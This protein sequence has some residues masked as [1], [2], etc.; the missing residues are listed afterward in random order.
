MGQAIHTRCTFCHQPTGS[1]EVKDG[2]DTYCN[3][4]CQEFS[5]A[6]HLFTCQV[7]ETESRPS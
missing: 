6:T 3:M 5:K 1:Q 4:I 2:D 7:M